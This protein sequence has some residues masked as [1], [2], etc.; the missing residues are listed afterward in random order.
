MIHVQEESQ[1]I[2]SKKKSK[3]DDF[4]TTDFTSHLKKNYTP[5]HSQSLFL[6]R[7]RSRDRK[8]REH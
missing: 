6:T 4:M 1:D 5:I 2:H 8:S 7:R 3:F